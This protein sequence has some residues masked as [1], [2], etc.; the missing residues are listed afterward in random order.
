MSDDVTTDDVPCQDKEAASEPLR[1]HIGCGEIVL[2][3]F[4]PIDRKQGQEA[5]P[6]DGVED[7]S[8]DE[9]Y[10]SH[11]LEHFSHQDVF[12]VLCHWVAKLRPGGLIRIAVPDTKM[13][14]EQYL[15]GEPINI[16][17]YLMGGHTDNDDV[18][19]CIFD[20]E[21][22]RELMVKAGLERVAPWK[23]EV[24]DCASLPISLNLSGC[25]PAAPIE[26]CENT[27]AVLSAPRFGPIC[28]HRVAAKAFY[29]ARVP[30][31][32]GQGAYWHQILCT[33][34]DDAIKIPDNEF[35]ITCD[36]DTIFTG[37]DVVELY[38]LMRCYP[39]ADA[40]C[41][42]QSKR[43]TDYALL[44]MTGDD[45][46]PRTKVHVV[47]FD[48]NLTEVT[49]AHFGLTIFRSSTLREF[50][51]PWM[52]PAPNDEGRWEDGRTDADIDFW[53]KWRKAGNTL[54][55]ANRVPVGHLEEVV[56][57]PSKAETSF[58]PVFQRIVDYANE[59]MPADVGR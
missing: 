37:E 57:W 12:M 18:H 58:R 30:Y 27:V 1:L 38:R 7:G 36:Y 31:N 4:V 45:D 14:A 24:A 43:G 16:Q 56:V 9:I 41:A 53:F 10:A 52:V 40:I 26:F 17:G 49:T 32:M 54:C 35:V 44:G 29:Q 50:P 34:M 3:G 13:I 11:I 33:Q 59:G 19:H 42:V 48:R 25:K 5:F 15:A 55:V 8:V 51:R 46:K 22:L 23:S 6:L 39:D 2:D 47:E 20:E 28:H 21:M